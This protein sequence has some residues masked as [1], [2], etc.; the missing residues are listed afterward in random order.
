VDGRGELVGGFFFWF[1]DFFCGFLRGCG[2]GGGE[3]GVLGVIWFFF[4]FSLLFFLVARRGLV[5]V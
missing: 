4:S 1:V 5:W 3:G 2:G